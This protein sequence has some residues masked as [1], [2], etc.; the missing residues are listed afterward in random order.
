MLVH[1]YNLKVVSID[2]LRS[3]TGLI[4]GPDIETKMEGTVCDRRLTEN[5]K[6]PFYRSRLSRHAVNLSNRERR[7]ES[8]GYMPH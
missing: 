6:P 8:S 3:E 5:Q 7:T 4:H 1:S 2:A